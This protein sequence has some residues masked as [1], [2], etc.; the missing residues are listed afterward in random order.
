MIT[1]RRADAML[2][3]VGPIDLVGRRAR[4]TL[5]AGY[6]LL[7]L[8]RAGLTLEQGRALGVPIDTTRKDGIGANVMRL[9]KLMAR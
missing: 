7:E 5:A 2:S 1:G 8:E 4:A 9:R 3:A 6:S